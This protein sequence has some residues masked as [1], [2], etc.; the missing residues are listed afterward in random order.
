VPRPR[1]LVLIVLAYRPRRQYAQSSSFGDERHEQRL[2]LDR[3]A[4]ARAD[5]RHRLDCRGHRDDDGGASTPPTATD[6]TP[7]LL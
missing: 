7:D 2:R 1:R 3:R 4:A 6:H 5:L